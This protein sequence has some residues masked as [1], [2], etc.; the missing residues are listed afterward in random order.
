MKGRKAEFN[1]NYKTF[2]LGGLCLPDDHVLDGLP[3]PGH[4]HGIGQAQ[5]FSECEPRFTPVHKILKVTLREVFFQCTPDHIFLYQFTPP[6][7]LGRYAQRTRGLFSSCCSTSYVWYRT[8]PAMSSS[9]VGPQVGWGPG[10]SQAINE[11][12]QATSQAM[13]T[14]WANFKPF[15]IKKKFKAQKNIKP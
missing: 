3:G 1:N 5:V 7:C 13:K 14:P 2:A 8:M 4:V 15:F 12:S 6:E 9:C 10:T 11:I